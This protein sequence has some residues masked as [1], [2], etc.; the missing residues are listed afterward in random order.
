[1]GAEHPELPGNPSERWQLKARLDLALE[2]RD[3]ASETLLLA[4]TDLMGAL[5]SSAKTRLPA[6][7]EAAML[8][9]GQVRQYTNDEFAIRNQWHALDMK[10]LSEQANETAVGLKRATWVLVSATIVLAIA[11]VALIFATLNS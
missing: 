8:A 9:E 2:R 10:E 6:L 11:T 7:R 4:Q 1:M 5:H 3:E